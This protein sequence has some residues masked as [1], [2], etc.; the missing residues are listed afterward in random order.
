MTV[1][2]QVAAGNAQSLCVVVSYITVFYNYF[3][4]S[5]QTADLCAQQRVRTRQRRLRYYST[6]F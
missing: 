3:N 1:A 4:Y 2:T 5:N 6:L